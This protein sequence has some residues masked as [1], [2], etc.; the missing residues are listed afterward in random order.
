MSGRSIDA[1][2][3]A[4][5]QTVS[6]A[7]DVSDLAVPRGTAIVTYCDCPHDA[8]AALAARR[9]KELGYSNVRPLAGGIVAWRDAGLPLSAKSLQ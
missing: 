8:T 6:T 1:T 4:G 9:L 5:F 2:R 3:Q 7:P